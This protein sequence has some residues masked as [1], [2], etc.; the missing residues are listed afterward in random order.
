M[1]SIA[2]GKKNR[3]VP[4]QLALLLQIGGQER[5]FSEIPP[6]HGELARSG[7]RFTPAKIPVAYELTD[8]DLGV[9]FDVADHSELSGVLDLLYPP[10]MRDWFTVLACDFLCSIDGQF[11]WSAEGKKFL[12]LMGL[13]IEPANR[14]VEQLLSGNVCALAGDIIDDQLRERLKAQ[15]ETFV[16]QR[17]SW[18]EKYYSNLEERIR[19]LEASPPGETRVISDST[20]MLRAVAKA[21]AFPIYHSGLRQYYYEMLVEADRR[22][23]P[24]N[25][26]TIRDQVAQ[27]QCQPMTE[28]QME[29]R[30]SMSAQYSV[31]EDYVHEGV[32]YWHQQLAERCMTS[33]YP[34][35]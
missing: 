17:V 7:L 23:Y 26:A 4:G 8:Q 16:P 20:T 31:L 9:S 33:G 24:S 3:E 30:A 15:V 5:P 11:L 1:G 2:T 12:S 32:R 6:V 29:C 28:L 18:A 25:L 14:K 10:D 19:E 22:R 27:G 35:P 21:I 34:L 13:T